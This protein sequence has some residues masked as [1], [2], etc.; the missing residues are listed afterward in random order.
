MNKQGKINVF[1]ITV[2]TVNLLAELVVLKFNA[3]RS[4]TFE[5][6]LNS[7]WQ[8]SFKIYNASTKV[9]LSLKFMYIL[10]VC[11]F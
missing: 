2:Q 1:T 8:L 11:L 4:N 3:G 9:K 6:D 7:G 10:L 5:V